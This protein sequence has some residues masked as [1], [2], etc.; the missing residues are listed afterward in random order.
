[1]CTQRR[2]NTWLMFLLPGLSRE[3]TAFITHLSEL[4]T[5]PDA[6]VNIL[7]CGL[8]KAKMTSTKRVKQQNRRLPKNSKSICAVLVHI[9]KSIEGT[10]FTLTVQSTI[11]ISCV[12]SATFLNYTEGKPGGLSRSETTMLIH[13]TTGRITA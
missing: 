8:L 11:D 9:F 5:G 13:R 2:S 6:G 4:G 3:I 1:M 12:D 7:G 10:V